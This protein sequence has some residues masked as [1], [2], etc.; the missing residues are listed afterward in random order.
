MKKGRSGRFAAALFLAAALVATLMSP[1]LRAFESLPD[2]LF[3]K[4]GAQTELRFTLPGNAE[5]QTDSAAVISSFDQSASD[6]GNTVTLTAGDEAGE[7]TLTY[8]LLGLIPVK[9]VA[10]TVETERTLVPGGQSVGVALLT[11]GVVV[12]GSSDVGK[13]PSPAYK[14]GIRAGD[15]IVRV[16]DT[17]GHRL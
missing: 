10:V 1:P 14:A 17:P 2:A 16:G 15:R 12:V 6:L 11:E 4:S 8:R 5:L 13:T 9:T 7:A 3:L